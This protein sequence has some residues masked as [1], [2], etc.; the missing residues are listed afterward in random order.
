MRNKL[1]L[2][3]LINILFINSCKKK[4]NED[5]GTGQNGLPT[6]TGYTGTDIVGNTI[7]PID[8]T[9]WRTTD[10]W[11]QAEKN[12]FGGTNYNSNCTFTDS[13]LF[14]NGRP[15][16]TTN[17][18]NVDLGPPINL[19]GPSDT[20]I[21]TEALLINQHYQKLKSVQVKGHYTFTFSLDS[22]DNNM[23]DTIFRV[24]YKFTDKNNCVRCGHGDILR[25]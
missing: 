3:L 11:S 7:G 16:P 14:A 2:L 13:N 10:I 19:S 6:I 4:D 25:K 12:L 15:N 23:S 18:A 24:Y 21:K 22:L 5:T 17:I 1:I 20:T 9:D 8:H